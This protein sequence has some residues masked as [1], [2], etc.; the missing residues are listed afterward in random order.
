M[1]KNQHPRPWRPKGSYPLPDGSYALDR[2]S[3]PDKH[4]RRIRTTANLNSGPDT[5]WLAFAAIE[6]AKH[7]DKL[8]RSR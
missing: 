7:L 8:E 6:L 1:T 5:E 4:G 3:K 2:V